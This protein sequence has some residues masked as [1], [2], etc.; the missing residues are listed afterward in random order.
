MKP[1]QALAVICIAAVLLAGCAAAP[2]GTTPAGP[3]YEKISAEEAKDIMDSEDAIILDVRSRDEYEKEHIQNA[4]SLPST[5]IESLAEEMLPDKNATILIYCK[6]GKN[7]AEAAEKLVKMGY[8]KVYDFGG[9]ED[10]PYQT[11]K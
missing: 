8:T 3:G 7:S 4:V 6:T 1:G 2:N 5:E 9:I 11:V 10:W